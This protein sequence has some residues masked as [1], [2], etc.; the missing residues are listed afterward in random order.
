MFFVDAHL[1]MAY[2]AVVHGRDLRQPLADL[3]R[4]EGL[5][6]KRG[7]ATVTFPALR[8]AGVALIFGTLF[9][10]PAGIPNL[11]APE[12]AVYHDADGAH[13][14]AMAQL[15]Y[16]H[17]LAD[18][19][20]GIRLVGD[21]EE[22]T[23][24]LQTHHP[25]AEADP[26]LGVAPLMEGADPIRGPEEVEEWYERGLRLVGLAWDDT[27]YAHGAWREGG[28]LTDA[29]RELLDALAEFGFIVDLTH[30]S[31][32]ASLETMERYEGTVV[33]TH[34]NARALVPGQRQLS[35]TQ[36]EAVG[37][38]DGVIGVVLYNRF[39]REGHQKGDP[40]ERVTLDHVVAHIDHICQRLGDAAHV[41]V[42]SD[43]DGG[44]GAADIPKEMDSVADLER[45]A[46]RLGEKGYAPEHIAGIMGENWVRLLRR[47]WT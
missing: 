34:S 13:K 15:D 24:V 18:A 23:A 43:F 5:K 41:G 31:E 11:N 19:E 4:A 25:D 16:Y 3:R 30:M 17:R 42:G 20:E 6:S 44:F 36:I 35:D 27:R 12:D 38:R 22:L 33:A 1:D 14:R 10:P 32:E 7:I 45:I 40:K 37:Q 39:L 46:A 26:L 2:N 47:A 21:V 28:G 9:V 29:G 8:Q